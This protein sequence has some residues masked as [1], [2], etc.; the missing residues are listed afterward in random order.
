MRYLTDPA[1]VRPGW[2][3]WAFLILLCLA[4]PLLAVGQHS[5][6]KSGAM[7]TP[8]R[9][10][11]YGSAIATHLML[12]LAVV[13]VQKH[14][15]VDLFLPFHLTAFGTVVALAALAL[16]LPLLTD[17][18]QMKDPVARER[19]RLMAPRSPGELAYFYVVAISAGISEQIAYRGLLFTLLAALVG[20]WWLAAVL[21][22]VPFGVVH[23]FQGWRSAGIITLVALRDQ[24][25]VG[26]TG[27]LVFAIAIHIIH[28]MIAGTV[29]CI[30]TRREENALAVP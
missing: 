17:R 20:S 19:T 15:H 14:S 3:G 28:D 13:A 27:T 12:L 23:A 29:L 25:V 18:F 21:A 8:T 6:L 7:P 26:L 2:A 30:R 5:A 1:F 24:I 11:I 9:R 10:E 16:G 4:L 22:A